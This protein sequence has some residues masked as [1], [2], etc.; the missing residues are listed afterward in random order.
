[1]FIV[2]RIDRRE[3][4]ADM[5]RAELKM[6]IMRNETKADML[7]A[8]LKMDRMSTETRLYNT[9]TLLV[10]VSAIFVPILLRKSS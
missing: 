7:R 1:L 3:T 9:F 6:D 8:E 10:A 2:S 4:K 5:L